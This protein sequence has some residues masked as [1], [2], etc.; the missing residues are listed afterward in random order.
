MTDI[1]GM[2][3]SIDVFST[4]LALQEE[5]VRKKT[6]VVIDVLRASSTIVTAL[7]NGVKAVIPVEDM[8]AAQKI[9]QNL[10]PSGYLLCGEKDGVKIQGY[11]LGNSPL[12]YDGKK[13]KGKIIIFNTTNG[14][15]AISRST[16]ADR[17]LIGSFLNLNT[18]VESLKADPNEII[19]VCAGWKNRFSLEDTLCAG[20]IIYELTDGKL[21]ENTSDGSVAAFSLYANYRNRVEELIRSSNHAM[22]L[23]HLNGEEDLAYCSQVSIL[24]VLP[25]YSQGMITNSK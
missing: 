21:P 4:S 23:K 3:P 9:S 24:D 25:V 17:L 18:V 22:R 14:T 12:E 5:D 15:K 7:N 6:V 11:E 19:L 16:G 8:E 10:D 1:K 13:V 20:N 2:S